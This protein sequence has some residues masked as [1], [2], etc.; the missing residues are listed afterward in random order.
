M[1][2]PFIVP[3]PI[4]SSGVT[5]EQV[6]ADGLELDRTS[7][8]LRI[9]VAEAELAHSADPEMQRLRADCFRALAEDGWLTA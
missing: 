4:K 3:S 1:R 6:Q 7:M 8:L 5:I 9:R 2:R